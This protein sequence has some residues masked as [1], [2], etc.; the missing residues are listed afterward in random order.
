MWKGNNILS[1]KGINRVEKGI[2]RKP[3]I[4]YEES[5]WRISLLNKL[6]ER[7][8]RR[9]KA[10]TSSLLINQLILYRPLIVAWYS[11]MLPGFGQLMLCRFVEGTIMMLLELI[12]NTKSHLNLSIYYTLI[13]DINDAKSVI[14]VH[15]FLAYSAFFVFAIRDAYHKSN[16]INKHSL[17]A[18]QEESPILPTRISALENNC[19]DLQNTREAIFWSLLCPGFGHL[20]INRTPTG[21]FLIAWYLM[22]CYQSN[23]FPAVIATCSGDFA[24]AASMVNPQWLLYLPSVICFA[25][26]DAYMHCEALNRAFKMEQARF[27]K[28]EYQS[29]RVSFFAQKGL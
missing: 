1:A 18:D 17:I 11:A 14:N 15:W 21:F 10:Y 25:A 6:F 7:T 3:A 13:G 26:N 28:S 22:A 27:F 23:L 9:P 19:L 5:L 20:F 2:I 24:A 4:T 12:L 29:G 16:I 8:V